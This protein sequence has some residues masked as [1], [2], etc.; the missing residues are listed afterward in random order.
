[1]SGH[2]TAGEELDRPTGPIPS[3]ALDD[4]GLTAQRARYA[5]LAPSV[6]RLRRQAGTL[7]LTFD[8]RFERQTLERALA[9]ERECC[10]FFEFELAGQRL[11]V[12]VAREA[13]RPALD[14]LAW[15]FEGA[16]RV[17]GRS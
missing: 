2:P 14:A 9:V 12:T 4:A 16:R 1:M 6:V 8:E 10:P 13:H 15:A 11:R 7:Q 5:S 3:C 17:G